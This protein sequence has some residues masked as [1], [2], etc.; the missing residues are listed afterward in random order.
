VSE[1]NLRRQLIGA[2][3]I[4][5][6]L[7]HIKTHCAFWGEKLAR[8]NGARFYKRT[9]KEIDGLPYYYSATF[10]FKRSLTWAHR[11]IAEITK[12]TG[13]SELKTHTPRN[14]KLAA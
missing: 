4:K 8:A 2:K 1:L 10:E 9:I 12:P 11:L 6:G 3:E 5:P 14:G 13:R 7:V